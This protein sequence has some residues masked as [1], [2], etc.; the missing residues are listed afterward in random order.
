[1]WDAAET[2]YYCGLP[3]ESTDHVVPQSMLD[4]WIRLGDLEDYDLATGRGRRLT[5]PSCQQC[6]S[7]LGG[8]YDPTLGDR[9]MRVK[10]RLRKKYERVLATPDWTPEQLATLGPRLR[11]H[12]ERAIRMRDLVRR[13]IAW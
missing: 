7:M 12:V 6:N 2:C 11:G 13:R 8:K 10:V 5:V 4:D 1:M 9:K 3:A